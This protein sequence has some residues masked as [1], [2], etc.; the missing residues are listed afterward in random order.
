[1]G[2]TAS[3]LRGT[4]FFRRKLDGIDIVSNT[5]KTTALR[6]KWHRSTAEETTLLAG[7]D[8]RI[9]EE[10]GVTVVAVPI[11]TEEYVAAR[12]LGTVPG[13]GADCLGRCLADKQSAAF[14]ATESL[15]QR[16][17]YL[18]RI[19]GTG[20]FL[21]ECHTGAPWVYEHILET[22]RSREGCVDPGPAFRHNG[23]NMFDLKPQA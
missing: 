19:M 4:P 21:E 12:A 8:V 10:G 9:A 11:G 20:T 3:I 15:E 7:T 13:G 6:P 16:M 2:V 1:M 22:S 23:W 18:E 14:V 5:A 17:R